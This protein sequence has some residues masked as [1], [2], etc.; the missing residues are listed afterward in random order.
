MAINPNTD[1]TAGAIL[2]AAQQNRFPRGVMAVGNKTSVQN[3]ITTATE[4]VNSGSF[5][6]VANRYYRITFT[7]Y[8]NYKTTTGD[9]QFRIQKT[10][11][12][13]TQ[14]ASTNRTA[15]GATQFGAT[16]VAVTTLT[17]G[18]QT[19]IGSITSS[20]GSVASEPSATA[21][22]QIIVEDIGPA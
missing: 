8:N 17:A 16:V 10:S 22:A 9:V 7:A 4:I 2:T 18:A 15:V 5:T 20:T 19:V 14:I 1:F 3:G 13:G 6:A 11:T 12:A 21:P